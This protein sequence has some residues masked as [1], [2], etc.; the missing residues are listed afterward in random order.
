M[1]RRIHILPKKVFPHPHIL[2]RSVIKD[3]L[4]KRRNNSIRYIAFAA[5]IIIL[6]FT[7]CNNNN[8]NNVKIN[9]EIMK[10]NLDEM[11]PIGSVEERFQSYNVE[12]VEVV[13]GDFWKPY[14][15]MDSLPSLEDVATY[16]VSQK[17]NPLYRKLDPINL[18]DKRLVNLAKGLAPAYVRVSGPGPTPYIF[19]MTINR[20]GQLLRVL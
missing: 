12:M 4:K 5:L 11:A 16:D 7:A 10:I 14:R 1:V 9:E 18:S 3:S 2:W 8:N 20:Q 6:A 15:F 17:D 19:K 13:G